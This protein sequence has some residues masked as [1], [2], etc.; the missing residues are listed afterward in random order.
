M[1]ASTPTRNGSRVQKLNSDLLEVEG[2]LKRIR[3]MRGDEITSD[4]RYD[5]AYAY[6]A[7]RSRLLEEPRSTEDPIVR[8]YREIS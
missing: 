5:V 7:E 6:C 1:S 3:T 2:Q 4:I 8:S